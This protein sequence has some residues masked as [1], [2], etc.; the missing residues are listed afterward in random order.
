MEKVGLEEIVTDGM[1]D[2]RQMNKVRDMICNNW[3]NVRAYLVE[4]DR[5]NKYYNKAIKIE[6]E[7]NGKN[8]STS[9]SSHYGVK[10]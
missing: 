9:I 2:E 3:T 5:D 6:F 4:S 7:M 8:H 1:L 10:K